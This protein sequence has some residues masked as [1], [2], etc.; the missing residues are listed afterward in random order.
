MSKVAL[1][2]SLVNFYQSKGLLTEERSAHFVYDFWLANL[3]SIKEIIAEGTIRLNLASL[4]VYSLAEAV[5]FTLFGKTSRYYY[6]EQLK[7]PHS[8]LLY[9]VFRNGYTHAFKPNRLEYNDAK[10]SWAWSSDTSPSGFRDYDFGERDEFTGEIYFEPDKIVDYV[11]FDQGMR[12]F[13]ITLDR[14][15]ARIE[16]DLQQRRSICTKNDTLHWITGKIVNTKA[17][18]GFNRV[19]E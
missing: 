3:K 2:H 15:V 6:E 7:I 4:G 12:Q 18:S 1:N 10:I 9:E 5:S 8:H 17:P 14:L 13:S 19:T 16:A 11:E